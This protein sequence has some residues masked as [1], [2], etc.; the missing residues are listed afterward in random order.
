LIVDSFSNGLSIGHCGQS[1]TRSPSNSV[2]TSLINAPA[3]RP[4]EL[5][6]AV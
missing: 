5:I 1:L 4:L 3:I 2:F 6:V